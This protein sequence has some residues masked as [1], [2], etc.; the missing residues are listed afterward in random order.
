[1]L[2]C[3][4]YY[5]PSSHFST[6]DGLYLYLWN[7]LAISHTHVFYYSGN[8]SDMND[9][10]LK[11]G[12]YY[13]VLA[14]A[15]ITS[16][17]NWIIVCFQLYLIDWLIGYYYYCG[18]QYVFNFIADLRFASNVVL[19]YC[20]HV[21]HEDCLPAHNTVSK[22]YQCQNCGPTEM[23]YLLVIL[24]MVFGISPTVAMGGLL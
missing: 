10:K 23:A 11:K 2:L 12:S 6:F 17:K 16:Y 1:M 20:H 7:I 19:F 21:F 5:Q 14:N 13:Y 4:R 15:E 18:L 3:I 22:V 24:V 9:H 8:I